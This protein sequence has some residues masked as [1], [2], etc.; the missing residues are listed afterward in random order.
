MTSNQRRP[1]FRLPW[2]TGPEESQ[3][4]GDA[5]AATSDLASTSTDASSAAAPASQPIPA[6]A[7]AAPGAAAAGSEPATAAEGPTGADAAPDDEKPEDTKPVDA[8]PDD[9]KPDDAKPD[10]TKPQDPGPIDATPAEPAPVAAAEPK[11]AASGAGQVAAATAPQPADNSAG[12]MRDL[13]AAMRRVAEETRQAGLSDLRTKAEERVRTLEAD[14][15]AR[16]AELTARAD[17]DV[18]A[19]GAWAEAEAQ[20]MKSEA[21]QRVVARKAQ[22]DQQLAAETTRAEAEAD[23]LRDRVAEY[24]RA[25]DAYHAQLS[26]ISDPSAFAAAA[27]RMPPA[28]RLAGDEEVPASTAPA[29][30]PPITEPASAPATD[31]SSGDAEAA[32]AARLA[33]L[34]SGAV[35][36]VPAANEGEPTSTEVR[37]SGL[38][39]FGAITGFRQALAAAEGIEGV[40]LSLGPTGEFVFRAV[41]PAG[42]NVASTIAALEGDAATIEAQPDG[43]LRVTLTRAH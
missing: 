38:G 34:D 23:A 29:A 32:L 8:K 6:D 2:G 19:V 41:H 22:L 42:F 35:T 40:S 28:P 26:D 21:E 36:S 3:P 17:R 10:D 24:E 11:V 20:R 27:K 30:E 5:H 37:V 25:L 31:A 13:V 43:G 7:A 16:R 14:A 4:E 12:F 18:E 33:E 15:E 1:G 39:S 9:H